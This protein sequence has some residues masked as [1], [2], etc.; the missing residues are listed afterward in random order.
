MHKPKSSILLFGRTSYQHVGPG[1]DDFAAVDNSADIAKLTVG[2]VEVIYAGS[3][4][5]GEWRYRIVGINAMGAWAEE[6]SCT[7]R[8]LRS[9]EVR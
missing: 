5:T 2:D 1:D 9:H 3:P 6:L 8:E 4:G 7:V